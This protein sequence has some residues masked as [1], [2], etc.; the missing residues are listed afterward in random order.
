MIC[1]IVRYSQLYGKQFLDSDIE[2]T[3]HVYK[4][5]GLWRTP[6]FQSKPVEHCCLIKEKWAELGRKGSSGQ[7][8][9]AEKEEPA[10]PLNV[11]QKLYSGQSCLVKEQA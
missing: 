9:P 3:K 4:H 10:K 6:V 2:V 8:R 11:V 7:S 5:W 1:F